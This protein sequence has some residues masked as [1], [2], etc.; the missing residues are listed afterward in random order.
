MN[1]LIK[2]ATILDSSSHL[3]NTTNDILIE[4]GIIKNISKTIENTNN[5][6]EI[7]YPN[8]HISQ[9]WFDSSICIGEPGFEEKETIENGLRTAALSGFSHIALNPNTYP[10]IDNSKYVIQS[11]KKLN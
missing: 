1:L 4:N 10:I 7:T 3:H 5:Y 2:S 8:L 6:T 9:G 11:N